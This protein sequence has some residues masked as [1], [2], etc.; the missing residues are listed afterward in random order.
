MCNFKY[1]KEF[2]LDGGSMT[3]TIP[4]FLTTC[5]PELNELDLSYNQV[6][7]AKLQEAPVSMLLGERISSYKCL[8][9]N[10]QSAVDRYPASLPVGDSITYRAGSG[11]QPGM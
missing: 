8:G 11:K 3:G 2:D 6:T 9:W 10:L 7:S 5:F 4:Q 1:L